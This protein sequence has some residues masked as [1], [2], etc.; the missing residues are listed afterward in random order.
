[1]NL[2]PRCVTIPFVGGPY[3]CGDRHNQTG[4]TDVE[5]DEQGQPP[6]F[7]ILQVI[8]RFDPSLDPC[9]GS[10]FGS[11]THFYDLATRTDLDG[12]TRWVYVYAGTDQRE[13]NAA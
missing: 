9:R 2:A 12:T 8:G 13:P 10:Q 7:K 4:T 1:M 11:D 5:L 3:D 6:A